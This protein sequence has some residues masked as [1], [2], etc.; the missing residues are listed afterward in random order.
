MRPAAQLREGLRLRDLPRRRVGEADVAGLSRPHEVVERAH[1]LVDRRELIPAVHPVQ[2]DVIGLQPPQRLLA[3]GCDRL[4]ARAAAVRIALIEVAEEL[5]RDDDAVAARAVASD[6]VA[7]D[8]LGVPLRVDVGGVDEIAAAFH[9][10][11]DDGFGLGDARPPAPVV[12]ERH[13]PET[14]GTDA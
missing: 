6:E 10:A 2:I 5:G 7:D 12:A 8:L 14:E 13:R 1:R 11:R 3:R 9:E 4:P